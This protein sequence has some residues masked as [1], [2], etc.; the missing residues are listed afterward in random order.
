MSSSSDQCPNI[1]L[2]MRGSR[3]GDRPP[4]E[5]RK[6]IGFPIDTGLDPLKITKLPSQHS[7]WG[8]YWPASKTP[9]QWRYAGRPIIACFWWFLGL[10]SPK[11]TKTKKKQTLS[12]LDPRGVTLIFSYIR[13]L[14]PFFGVQNFEFQYYY[15]FFLGGG[16]GFRK[17]SI[18]L[19]KIL[20]IFF[21]GGGRGLGEVITKLDYI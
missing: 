17:M 11:K 13:R 2:C 12:E 10:R 15:F 14:G 5:N 18:F 7:M 21:L 20:W 6:F 16:G 19:G 4:S 3:G 8:H 1:I 9:F